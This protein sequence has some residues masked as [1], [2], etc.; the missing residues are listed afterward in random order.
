MQPFDFVGLPSRAIFGPGKIT[1]LGE[2]IEALGA[3]RALFCC[4]PGRVDV[5]KIL[6]ESVGALTAGIC[7]QALPFT[8]FEAAEAGRYTA[9]DLGADCL[10]SFGGGNAVGFAKAIALELDIPIIAIPTTL[11]GSETTA[12]QGIIKD[13]KRVQNASPRM[14]ARTLIYDPELT[15]DLP[16]SVMIPSG[17]NS[18]AH[19]VGALVAEN[20]NPMSR[21][22]AQEG[23]AAMSQ[24]LGRIAKDPDDMDARSQAF[25]GAW[26][27]ASTLKLAPGAVNVH[28]KLCHTIGGGFGLSHANVHTIILPHSSAYNRE[29]VPQAMT[30]ISTALGDQTSDAPGALFDLLK[31]AGAPMALRDVGMPEDGIETVADQVA[32]DSYYSNPRPIE[33]AGILDLIEDAWHGRRPSV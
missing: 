31:Q 16:L 25:Y 9:R 32:T 33:R 8:P 26:L 7:D 15:R 3:K 28:H 22:F 19:A 21:L 29:A 20:G 30:S 24:A 2:E 27:N 1:V 5:V 23:L 4:S 10:V 6:A 14:Q 13:G 11:S 17:G 18:M 12:L